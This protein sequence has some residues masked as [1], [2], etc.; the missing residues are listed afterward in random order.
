MSPRCIKCGEN[1]RTSD[2]PQK[3]RSKVPHCNEDGH[4]ASHRKCTKFPK[5]RKLDSQVKTKNNPLPT[6]IRPVTTNISF[7]SVC[8][9]KTNNQMAL[10]EEIATP[11]I[12][13]PSEKERTPPSIDTNINFGNFATYIAE[14]QNLINKF[15]EIFLAFEEMSKTNNDNEKL[16]IFLLAIAKSALK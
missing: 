1:H 2:C 10:R 12:K 8:S 4:I 5:T 7:A 14:I 9:N 15:P 6:N 13:K 16:S 11:P 3:E